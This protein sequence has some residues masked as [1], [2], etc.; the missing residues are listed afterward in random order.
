MCKLTI[1]KLNNIQ[2][3][4]SSLNSKENPELNT[5]AYRL[6]L[7]VLSP[8][9]NES[10]TKPQLKKVLVVVRPSYVLQEVDMFRIF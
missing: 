10:V 9:F 8:I 5:I 3:K 2:I 7:T 4:N 1:A 6:V